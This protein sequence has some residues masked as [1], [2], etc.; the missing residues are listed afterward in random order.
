VTLDLD[1]ANIRA[2]PPG[3]HAGIVVLRLKHQDKIH[4]CSLT[5]DG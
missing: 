1:F 4:P 3:K 2:Y 5:F